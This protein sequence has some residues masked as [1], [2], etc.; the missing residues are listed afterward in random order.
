MLLGMQKQK[1]YNNE[2]FLAISQGICS[3]INN[4]SKN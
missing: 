4:L 1:K 3:K 2:S